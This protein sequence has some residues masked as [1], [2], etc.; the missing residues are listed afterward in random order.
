MRTNRTVYAAVIMAILAVVS[1]APRSNAASSADAA[2]RAAAKQKHY[3]FVTFYKNDAAGKDMLADVKSIQGK[4]AARADFVSVDV[5]NRANQQIVS[6]YGADRS[7]LP[8]TIAVAPNGAVTAGYPRQIKNNDVS[9]AFVSDGTAAVLKVLQSGRLAAVCI[10]NSKTKHNKESIAAING[11]N[12]QAKFRNVIAIVKVDPAD[13]DEAQ[14]LKR[15]QVDP[16]TGDAQIVMIAPPGKMVGRFNG[17][18][19]TAVMS[20]SLQK[21]LGGGCSGGSCGPG[22]CK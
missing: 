21:S 4:L 8:L 10:Q 1:I 2:I 5:G 14:F 12:K 17:A 15:C 11:L 13:R 9:N 20:A 3:V 22:G 16:T 6:R 18:A 19:S 7:P